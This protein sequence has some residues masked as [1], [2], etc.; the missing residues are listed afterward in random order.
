MFRSTSTLVATL[1]IVLPAGCFIDGGG[2]DDDSTA[3]SGQTTGE[4]ASTTGTQITVGSMTQSTA[5]TT[6]SVSAT[7]T[8]T[9]SSSSSSTTEETTLSE[10]SSS[11]GTTTG[12]DTGADT[13]SSSTTD[14]DTLSVDELQ[15]GDLVITEVMANPNC[16]GDDCEWFEIYNAT[17]FDIDLMNLGIGDRDDFESGT[18]GVFI[19]LSAVLPAGELGV[20]AQ[21]TLWPY[22][23][24][25]PLA[26]YSEALELSNSSFEQVAIFSGNDVLDVTATFFPND[27]SGRSRM[28]QSVFWDELDHTDSD[29]WCW[30]DTVLPS[31]STDDWGTP[32]S[33]LIECLAL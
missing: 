2:D 31:M 11:T 26:R 25:E 8:G 6:T 27:E 5:N 3:S 28:L 24:V 4:S 23:G 17:A 18:P 14:D 29:D 10:S 21:E 16:S 1:A 32:G 15:P 12:T 19:T 13:S 22:E 9:S 30:S 7:V 33:D 20:L